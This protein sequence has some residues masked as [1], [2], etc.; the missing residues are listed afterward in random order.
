MKEEVKR[1]IEVIKLICKGTIEERILELQDKK[2]LLSEKL[3][4][5][6]MDDSKYLNQ[7]NEEDIKNL[8]SYNND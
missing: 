2:K 6:D 7:L 8:I 5:K 3:L 4:E 1:I